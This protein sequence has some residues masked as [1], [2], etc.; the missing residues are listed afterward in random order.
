MT[1]VDLKDLFRHMQWADGEVWRAVLA[2]PAA[3]TDEPLRKLLLHLH[4]VQRAFLDLW[5]ERPLTFPELS[6]FPDVASIQAWSA[7][8]YAEAAA[9]LDRVDEAALTRPVVMPWADA[10][11]Q[12]LGFPPAQPTLAETIFQITS[13]STY[14]RGQV[15]A[16]LRAIGGE[17]RLVDYIAWVWF[18]RP[19]SGS[20]L[21]P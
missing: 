15:N 8:Y 12:Q 9:F 5:R 7:P 13:H 14:H 20:A 17:P 18:G 21:H 11:A 3:S 16:R 10:L 6:E 19:A 1:V 2:A 4:T